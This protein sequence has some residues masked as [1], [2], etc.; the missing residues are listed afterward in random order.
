MAD[1]TSRAPAGTEARSDPHPLAGRALAALRVYV[2]VVFLAAAWPKLTREGGFAGPLEGFVRG[3]GLEN[4]PAF[5]RPFLE[6]VVLPNAGAFT[7]LVVVGELLVALSLIGGAVTRLGALVAAF[8]T[9][10]Y[11]LTKGLWPWIPSSNDAPLMLVALALAVTAAG[12]T[13]GLDR[14]LRRRWPGVP[15]W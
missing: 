1:D 10:N 12:R 11:M 7:L 9:A 3:V 5:Y 8:M 4:A 2:G 14:A 13:W 6:G 15:L